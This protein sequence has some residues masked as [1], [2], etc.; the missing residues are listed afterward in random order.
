M[1]VWVVCYHGS[2]C[3]C[4]SSAA[5]AQCV[6]RAL[7]RRGCHGA[8]VTVVHL[9]AETETGMALVRSEA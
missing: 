3:G 8:T 7:E 1:R 6:Q 2:V 9:N 4:Y 5:D